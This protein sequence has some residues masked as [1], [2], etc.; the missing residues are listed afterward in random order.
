MNKN[1]KL[2]LLKFKFKLKLLNLWH[3]DCY[4]LIVLNSRLD[5]PWE[6]GTQG[7]LDCEMWPNFC[8]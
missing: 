1:M 3:L 6:Y 7:R 8:Y 2:S 4:S 5:L